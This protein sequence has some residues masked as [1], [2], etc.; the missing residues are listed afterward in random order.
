VAIDSS[1]ESAVAVGQSM[2]MGQWSPQEVDRTGR[3][4]I[5]LYISAKDRVQAELFG[6]ALKGIARKAIGEVLVHLHALREDL[7]YSLEHGHCR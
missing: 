6:I 5:Y 1:W 3:P 7:H 2:G 4:L